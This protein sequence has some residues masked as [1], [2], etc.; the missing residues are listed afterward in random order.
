MP[1]GLEALRAQD[2]MTRWVVRN[3][4]W[5]FGLASFGELTRQKKLITFREDEGAGE[6]C[7]E[8]ALFLFHQ[9]AFDWLDTVLA[10]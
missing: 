7:H 2:M 10:S 1:G 4:R 8:G 3:G 5:T 6:H 9:H